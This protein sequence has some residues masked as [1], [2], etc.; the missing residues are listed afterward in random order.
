MAI[1][2][3][4]GSLLEINFKRII[5]VPQKI[6]SKLSSRG[7]TMIKGDINDVCSFRSSFL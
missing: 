3:F 2:K 4:E 7:M 1:I 6:S 5:L